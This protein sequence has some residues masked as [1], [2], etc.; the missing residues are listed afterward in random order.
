MASHHSGT[1]YTTQLERNAK[2]NQT[3]LPESKERCSLLIPSDVEG[4]EMEGGGGGGG[5][6]EKLKLWERIQALYQEERRYPLGL[7][8][9]S[10]LQGA[11]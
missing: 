4:E 3:H 7:T 9:A 8:I 10:R 11:A 2:A 1:S 6:V 5:R